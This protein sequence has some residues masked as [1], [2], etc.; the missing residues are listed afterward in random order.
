MRRR[1]PL[2]TEIADAMLSD[3]LG[4][5]ICYDE[6]AGRICVSGT[7]P[8][9][10]IA[11]GT[12]RPWSS[13]DDSCGY[14]YAQEAFECSSERDSQHALSIVA[15]KRRMNPVVSLLDSLPK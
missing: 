1:D 2:I 15:D 14:A 8:W 3:A 11:R 5:A 13:V 7:L 12:Y 6:L 4:E 9:E 10:E